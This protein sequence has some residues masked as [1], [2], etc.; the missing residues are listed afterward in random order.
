MQA[1]GIT[2][3]RMESR[4]RDPEGSSEMWGEWRLF[5]A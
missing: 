3:N 5:L 4:N 1:S 2:D